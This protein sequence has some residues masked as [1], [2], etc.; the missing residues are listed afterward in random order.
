MQ[1]LRAGRLTLQYADG[2]IWNICLG[3]EEL[4]R[5]VYLVFQDI[6][7]TSR[8]FVIQSEKWNIQEDS[9]TAEL[10]LSGT[11]DA[12]N[13]QGQLRISGSP[14]GVIT[15]GFS[16]ASSTDFMRNRLGLCLLH[17][18][19]DLA[20]KPCALTLSDGSQV[21]SFFPLEI[22]PNQ[23]FKDLSGISHTAATGESVKVEFSGEIFET[24]DHRNWS[25]ASYKT[26]CTPIELPFPA[27]VSMGEKI[28]QEIRI[29]LEGIASKEPKPSDVE[30]SIDISPSE[31][32]LPDIG[33]CLANDYSDSDHQDFKELCIK[34]LRLDLDLDDVDENS[35][36]SALEVT[37]ELSLK[38]EI[39]IKAATNYQLSKFL[40]TNLDLLGSV[41]NFLIFSKSSKI[42][43]AEF[44]ST[45]RKVLGA[46]ALISGGTDLYFT[47]I[48]RG[49]PAVPGIDQISFSLNP[50]VHSFD[51]RTVIQNLATQDVIGRN[52]SRIARGLKIG[53][54]PISL[55]PRF[56]P[57]ATAPE[58]DVSNTPLPAS[59]D[60]RQMTWFAEAWTAVSIKYLA[61]SRAINSAT[62]FETVGWR[63]VKERS[64]GSEDSINF[65]S[66]PAEHFPVWNLFAS[67]KGFAKCLPTNSN[68]PEFV[69]ALVIRNAQVTRLI[70]VNF[71]NQGQ[72]VHFKGLDLTS[73][74]LPPS[75][76]TYL[77]I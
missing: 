70:L 15:Y 61:Q 76:T 65:P 64:Q 51:D 39:S 48:N 17:P 68:K 13:F 19:A 33:L 77:D 10:E 58:K 22:S 45:A 49:N 66:K 29:S 71:S 2:S 9:F 18:I 26:Y 16:G 59:V 21:A 36:G 52:A 56:N 69:D 47:E 74:E 42:T 44:I 28:E 20:G 38:L 14:K 4:I 6:N 55:H 62:Y 11:K 72:R 32:D 30:I 35:L 12:A 73:V 24:E 40:T 25:D 8:P 53:V 31:I 46:A 67:L 60:I 75:C 27:K 3:G 7:W 1:N 23:P 63:G 5:R 43:P 54:G 34:H 57:N 37:K 41:S 50:Q